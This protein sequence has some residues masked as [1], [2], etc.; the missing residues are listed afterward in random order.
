MRSGTS[1]HPGDPNPQELRSFGFAAGRR[2]VT[3][4]DPLTSVHSEVELLLLLRGWMEYSV[5]GNFVRFE[6]G[7]LHVFWGGLPH[8]GLRLRPP[9]EYVGVLVPLAWVLAW[10]LANG[11]SHDLVHGRMF[12]EPD[13]APAR[14]RLDKALMIGWQADLREGTPGVREAVAA[15]VQARLARLAVS[16]GGPDTSRSDR[17]AGSDVIAGACQFIIDNYRDPITLDEVAAAAGAGKRHLINVFKARFDE[18][19]WDYVLRLRLAHA[20]RLLRTS[21]LSVLDVAVESG[22]GSP[23]R[24]YD[25]F[26]RACAESPQHYREQRDRTPT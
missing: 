18:S 4:V 14:R 21:D 3:A 8:R 15:A 12:S 22:F 20:Q 1:V 2:T 13:D 24:F 9:T 5:A 25:A 19:V 17:G 7:R 23:A 26:R 10:P 11:F 16:A 6:P